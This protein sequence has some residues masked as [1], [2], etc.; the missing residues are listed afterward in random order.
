MAFEVEIP[1]VVGLVGV[2]YA[3]LERGYKRYLEQK[4]IDPSIKFDAT[5]MLNLLVSTG[6]GTTIVSTI[7]PALLAALQTMGQ[8]VNLYTGIAAILIN[9]GLGYG[10]TYRILD[11]LN[12]STDKKMEIAEATKS[13]TTTEPPK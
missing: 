8:Q 4:K 11:G 5:Y 1:L 9:F 10:L 12:N 13:T 2:G 6:V 3:V 7:V